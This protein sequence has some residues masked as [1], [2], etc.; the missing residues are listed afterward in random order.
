MR[1]SLLDLPY[2]GIFALVLILGGYV[3]Y[4]LVNQVSTACENVATSIGAP[5]Y[6]DDGC[7]QARTAMGNF[8]GMIG[9][10][11]FFAGLAVI[12]YAATVQ[13]SMNYIIVGLLLWLISTVAFI[14][15]SE[16]IQDIFGGD[17]FAPIV[18]SYPLPATVA[19][20]LHW[21]IALFGMVLIAVLYR[22]RSGGS[23]RPEG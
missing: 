6:A 18:A 19:K 9:I 12:I 10:I 4:G 22:G 2:L 13:V 14:Q 23:G 15:T 17:F 11:C 7:T 5:S 1:G 3:A 21:L 20:N 16:A 8:V